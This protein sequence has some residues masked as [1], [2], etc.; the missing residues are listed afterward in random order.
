MLDLEQFSLT[1]R[2]FKCFGTEP[3]GFDRIAKLNL[4]VGRNNS[5][6]SSLL[7]LFP[8]VTRNDFEFPR[9][10]WHGD[11]SPAVFARAPIPKD[12]VQSVFREKAQGGNIPTDHWRFGK[13]YMV[14]PAMQGKSSGM[15]KRMLRPYIRPFVEAL[16]APGPD[17]NSRIPHLI[18]S[19][20]SLRAPDPDRF[21][22]MQVPPF[23]P[24]LELNPR[25]SLTVSRRRYSCGRDRSATVDRARAGP[26]AFSAGHA[27]LA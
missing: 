2:N 24:S 14:R 7:D 11:K 1:I 13:P 10:L 12:V 17:G 6:K 5:G 26:G 27:E 16:C 15:T 4:I 21:A 8:F 20:A 18:I 3:H 25:N 23:V 22:G 9:R 19:S